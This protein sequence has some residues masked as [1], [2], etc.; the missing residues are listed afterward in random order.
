MRFDE[1][2]CANY[3]EAM[4]RGDKLPPV[5]V[6]QNKGDLI[7]ADGV[8]RVR[9]ARKARFERIG[10]VVHHG[11]GTDASID[12]S[13]DECLTTFNCSLSGQNLIVILWVCRQRCIDVGINPKLDRLCQSHIRRRNPRICIA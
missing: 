7:L 9:A 10:A 3:A 6:F 13:E 1:Q 8:H 11:T 5:D 4:I 12:R 2:T